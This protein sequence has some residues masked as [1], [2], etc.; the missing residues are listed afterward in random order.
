MA[1]SKTNSSSNYIKDKQYENSI[2]DYDVKFGK[3][4]RQKSIEVKAWQ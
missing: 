1:R 2:N 3:L 4:A